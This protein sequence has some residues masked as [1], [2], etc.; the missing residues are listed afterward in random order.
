MR[1]HEAAAQ[2][3]CTQRAIKFYEEKGLLPPV[4]RGENGYRDFS[5][6]DI[7]VLQEIHAYRK[8]GISIPDIRRLLK[9][10]SDVLL[11]DILEKKK[12]ESAKQQREIDALQAY[13][14][15]HEPHKLNEAVDYASLCDTIR[16]QLPGPIG[17]YIASHFE[18][19]LQISITTE[20]QKD[21]LDRIL[22]FWDRPEIRPT[23]LMRMTALFSKL[24]P[25]SNA[26]L[27]D[28]QIASMLHPD[29]QT[30]ERLKAQTLK[31]VRLRENPLIH[32]SPTELF[33]RQTAKAFKNIGYYD[34]FIP[35]MKRLSPAY[36]AYHDA[37]D[38]LNER[39]CQDLGL[40]YDAQFNLRLK[41]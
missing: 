24:L 19:Y 36:K 13:M 30:Y 22:A 35:Q 32:F 11:Q 27:M 29:E 9:G 21:A 34:L 37:L 1:I 28:Q 31:T 25:A 7:R 14:S 33:K 10:N 18:P 4:T 39:L 41:Q 26:S 5:S 15:R 23:I 20:E 2:V 38:A 8:L 40:Y 17:A 3:G 6:E 12:A 16:L